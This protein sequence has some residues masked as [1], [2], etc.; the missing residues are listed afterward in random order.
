MSDTFQVFGQSN[1]SELRLILECEIADTRDAFIVDHIGD[2]NIFS[3][4]R[5]GAYL[6]RTVIQRNIRIRHTV[7][8]VYPIRIKRKVAHKNVLVPII[9]FGA[10]YIVIPTVKHGIES[11]RFGNIL[12]RMI[13][14]KDLRSI[15]QFVGEHIESHCSALFEAQRVDVECAVAE[16]PVFAGCAQIIARR[17]NQFFDLKVIVIFISRNAFKQS[18]CTRN[19]RRSKTRAVYSVITAAHFCRVDSAGS[20]QIDVFA[21]IRVICE[22]PRVFR[23][24]ADA[25]YV[26]I[27]RRIC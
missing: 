16:V 27:R 1:L 8:F 22:I 10:L 5:I 3:L 12:Q 15:F 9:R 4:T 20:N 19:D 17:I 11:F 25:D 13:S 24:R 26:L 14:D 21:V 7:V 18:Q 23:K 2:R 6:Y